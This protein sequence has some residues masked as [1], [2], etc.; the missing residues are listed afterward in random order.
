MDRV[1]GKA[2]ADG[3]SD[4]VAASSALKELPRVLIETTTPIGAAYVTGA[5]G[6]QALD[7]EYVLLKRCEFLLQTQHVERRMHCLTRVNFGQ[8]QLEELPGGNGM[9]RATKSDTCGREST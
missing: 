6:S 1:R 5:I 7:H 8:P 9:S 4:V 3:Q 2:V